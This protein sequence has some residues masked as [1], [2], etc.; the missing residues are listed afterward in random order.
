M[1][2]CIRNKER[3]TCQTEHVKEVTHDF[4]MLYVRICMYMGRIMRRRIGG[5]GW[6]LLTDYGA[7]GG[8]SSDV[9][10]GMVTSWSTDKDAAV[11]RLCATRL[12]RDYSDL[13]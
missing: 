6:R 7:I 11:D 13:H 5:I 3:L 4:L 2:Y 1:L 10:V 8:F 12:E 9:S